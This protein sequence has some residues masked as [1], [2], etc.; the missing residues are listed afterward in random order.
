MLVQVRPKHVMVPAHDD[1]VIQLMSNRPVEPALPEN[2][3]ALQ[4]T[5]TDNPRGVSRTE[6][7]TSLPVGDNRRNPLVGFLD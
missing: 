4:R 2:V 7:N 6:A 3:C 5:A 1:N